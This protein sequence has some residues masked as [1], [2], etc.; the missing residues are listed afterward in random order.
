MATAS[1]EQ[2]IQA[3]RSGERDPARRMLLEL[4]EAEPTRPEVWLWLAGATDDAEWKRTYLR[5][6]LALNPQEQRAVAAL[7]KLGVAH[8]VPQLAPVVT[9]TPR[10]E[11]S[12]SA[13]PTNVFAAPRFAA[14][15]VR[16]RRSI[17]WTLLALL[18]AVAVL[19][20]LTLWLI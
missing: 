1:L 2:A 8:D 15:G 9:T 17:P 18:C 3:L 14:T 5:R 19:I 13:T 16:A 20:P 6:V 7:Q 10:I 12:A 11:K 4:S